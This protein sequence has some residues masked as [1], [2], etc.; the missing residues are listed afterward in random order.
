MTSRELVSRVTRA[1]FAPTSWQEAPQKLV[2]LVYPITFLRLLSLI[3]ID[4]DFTL[5][6]RRLYHIIQIY[7][8]AR[9]SSNVIIGKSSS[10]LPNYV[11]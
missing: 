7:T 6:A 9:I 2:Q 10:Q 11:L 8:W 5:A 1:T 4:H 3:F